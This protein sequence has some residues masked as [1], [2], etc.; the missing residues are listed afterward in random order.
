M[1]TGINSLLE[2][3]GLMVREKWEADLFM[4]L[5]HILCYDPIAL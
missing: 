2:K 5:L 4:Y 1:Y 3:E